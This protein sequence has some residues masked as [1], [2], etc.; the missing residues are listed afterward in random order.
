[1]EMQV[2]III[3]ADVISINRSIVKILSIANEQRVVPMIGLIWHLL[4]SRQQPENCRSTSTSA[5]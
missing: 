5:T 4:G 1:M 2:K 3:F